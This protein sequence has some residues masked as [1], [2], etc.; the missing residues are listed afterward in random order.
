MEV[1]GKLYNRYMHLV[2]GVCLK[3]LKNREESQDAVMQIF[4]ILLKEIP[5]H[6][7][8]IFKNWLYGV[9]KNYCLM[10]IRK[11]KS[12]KRK[13]ENY[14]AD[15]FMENTSE[16]HLIDKEAP[17]QLS[18]ALKQC[19]EALKEQQ[20]CC[21]AAFY[22]EEKCYKEIS[23]ELDIDIKKVKSFIQ[24]G[25][26]NLKLCLDNKTNNTHD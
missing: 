9:S 25:K 18:T 23:E 20:R 14:S 21:L 11:D 16:L 8:K 22:Y 7:I 10:K 5:K 12:E 6:E 17:D 2:Y 1:L 3:Y 26:R 19:M 15:F 24:N 4:E 13:H